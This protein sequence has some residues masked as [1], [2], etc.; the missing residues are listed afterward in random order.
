MFMVSIGTQWALVRTHVA[1]GHCEE[2]WRASG[3]E[4]HEYG[5]ILLH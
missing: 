2:L 5:C 1:L 3:T 4:L